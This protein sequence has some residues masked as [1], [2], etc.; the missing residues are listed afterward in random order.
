MD[1]VEVGGDVVVD[2]D[3]DAVDDVE[4]EVCDED[5]CERRVGSVVEVV[6]SFSFV[7]VVI[8]PVVDCS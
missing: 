4:E 2:A 3:E 5:V 7:E 6:E 1:R 8:A